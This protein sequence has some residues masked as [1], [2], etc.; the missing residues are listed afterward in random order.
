MGALDASAWAEGASPHERTAA[1]LKPTI[2]RPMPK[3][4]RASLNVAMGEAA[5]QREAAQT[6]EITVSEAWE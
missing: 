5:Q 2:M 1:K 4:S 3:L 6:P